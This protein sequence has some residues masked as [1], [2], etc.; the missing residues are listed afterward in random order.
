MNNID[1]IFDSLNKIKIDPNNPSKSFK[2]IQKHYFQIFTDL[3]TEFRRFE[4]KQNTKLYRVRKNTEDLA[5][6]NPRELSYPPRHLTPHGRVNL[7]GKPYYYCSD[8][9]FTSILELKPKE[10]DY[11]T[12]SECI[13]T[14]DLLLAVIGDTTRYN[15]IHNQSDVLKRFTERITPIITSPIESELE[16]LFTSILADCIFSDMNFNGIMYPSFYSKS[17]ADNF[18][19]RTDI[20]D[21]YLLFINAKLFKVVKRINQHHIVIKCVAK[22]N[23]ISL[24]GEFIWEGISGCQTHPID[25]DKDITQIEEP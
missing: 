13:L 6:I 10:N 22:T 14:K 16:Y 17:N 12:L 25:F 24:L 7:K 21:R 3:L 19:L 9:L 4:L 5:F 15:T 20:V 11:F 2:D 18:A 8:K 1:E 23:K